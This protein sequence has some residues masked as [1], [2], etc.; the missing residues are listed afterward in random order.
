MLKPWNSEKFGSDAMDAVDNEPLKATPAWFR[1]P[2]LPINQSRC[3]VQDPITYFSQFN[4]AL[5][6]LASNYEEDSQV[7]TRVES[8]LQLK[9]FSV[10]AGGG[11]NIY[12]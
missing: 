4:G 3:Q 9:T 11:W 10:P 6:L 1:C 7:D 5:K 2:G 8:W 12:E